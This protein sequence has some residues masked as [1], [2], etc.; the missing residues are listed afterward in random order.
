M[1]INHNSVFL[2]S[3]VTVAVKFS[4]KQSFTGSKWIGRIHNNQVVQIFLA[5]DKTKTVFIMNGKTGIVKTAGCF[6]KIFFA[7]FHHQRIDLYHVNSFDF[8]I[9]YQFPDNASVPSAD[10]QNPLYLGMNGH[11]YM[12]D[13]FMV[14][15]FIFFGKH[16]KAVQC[17]KTTKFWRIE[18]INSLKF[19]FSAV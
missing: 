15:K 7:Y 4:G 16:H 10:Y 2:Q 17:E 9:L 12:G 6:R 11:R 3:F 5:A 8:R 14:N 13:H 1:L 18:Y 19:T